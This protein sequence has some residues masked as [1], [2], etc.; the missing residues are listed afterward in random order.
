MFKG[1]TIDTCSDTITEMG[2][3]ERKIQFD[4]VVADI[5]HTDLTKEEA[6]ILWKAVKKIKDK[7]S[8]AFGEHLKRA[9]EI[10][11]SWPRWKREL[12]EQVLR[13]SRPS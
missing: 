2:K 13:P 3:E 5:S 1:I 4:A 7:R 8:D 9:S 11:A 6:N 12:A 10:V